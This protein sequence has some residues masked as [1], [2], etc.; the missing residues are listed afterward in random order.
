M[1][2]NNARTHIF[3]TCTMSLNRQAISGRKTSGI[4]TGYLYKTTRLSSYPIWPDWDIQ[5]FM[6]HSIKINVSILWRSSYST[7]LVCQYRLL[8]PPLRFSLQRQHTLLPSH[9][10]F[11]SPAPTSP[12]HPTPSNAP[13]FSHAANSSKTMGSYNKI[14]SCQ[15]GFFGSLEGGAEVIAFVM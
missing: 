4:S 2:I 14:F 10:F 8:R 7:G 3:V 9:H 12:S 13:V 1:C 6:N 5:S 15:L 11:T